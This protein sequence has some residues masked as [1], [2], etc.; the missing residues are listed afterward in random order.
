VDYSDLDRKRLFYQHVVLVLQCCPAL[1]F[2]RDRNT[3]EVSVVIRFRELE[4]ASARVYSC[5]H[6]QALDS[7]SSAPSFNK[8]D[9]NKMERKK[10]NMFCLCLLPYLL[11]F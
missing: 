9:I 5:T 10:K 3:R 2:C 7:V 6:I 4:Q 8:C 1:D 11:E